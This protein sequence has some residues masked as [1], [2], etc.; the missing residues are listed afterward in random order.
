MPSSCLT[1][2]LI[3][4]FIFSRFVLA[5]PDREDLGQFYVLIVR[6][7]QTLKHFIVNV[8]GHGLFAI[9]KTR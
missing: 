2:S 1:H 9:V 5:L 3:S 4:R 7:E 8:E 6:G